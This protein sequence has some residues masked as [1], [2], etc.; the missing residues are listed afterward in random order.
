MFMRLCPHGHR[1]EPVVRLPEM[2]RR[3]IAVHRK[4]RACAIVTNASLTKPG[5][6]TH[7]DDYLGQ[8]EVT[9]GH[10]KI[11]FFQYLAG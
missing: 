3:D 9:Q 1:L 2:L 11:A 5:V 7:K 8:P 4:G 10:G 6:R